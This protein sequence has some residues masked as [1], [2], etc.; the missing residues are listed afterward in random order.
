MASANSIG[1]AV[2]YVFDLHTQW[3]LTDFHSKHIASFSWIWDLP[4]LQSVNGLIRGVAGQLAPL[5]I[6]RVQRPAGQMGGGWL[7]VQ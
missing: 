3:G 1:A 6:A 5:P 7:M 4:R 2:P